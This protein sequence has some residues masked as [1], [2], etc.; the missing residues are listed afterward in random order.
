MLYPVLQK[1]NIIRRCYCI[2]NRI[3]INDFGSDFY[4][5]LEDRSKLARPAFNFVP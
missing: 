3:Y 2:G 5:E 4:V 1:L